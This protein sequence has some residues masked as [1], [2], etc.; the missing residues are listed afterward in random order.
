MMKVDKFNFKFNLDLGGVLDLEDDDMKMEKMIERFEK[1]ENEEL[2][3]KFK[4]DKEKSKLFI[5]IFKDL[6]KF[7]IIGGMMFI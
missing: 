3:L 6:S 2:L 7:V 5:K 4:K 1:I